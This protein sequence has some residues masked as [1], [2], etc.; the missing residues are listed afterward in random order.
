LLARRQ[1]ARNADECTKQAQGSEAVY[2]Y[3]VRHRS[4]PVPQFCLSQ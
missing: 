2:L 1:R 3:F 4:V